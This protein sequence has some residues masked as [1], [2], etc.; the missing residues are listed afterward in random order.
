M[1]ENNERTIHSG[2]IIER[3]PMKRDALTSEE[4]TS[5]FID[6]FSHC[7]VAILASRNWIREKGALPPMADILELVDERAK[8]GK[9]LAEK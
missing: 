4:I 1:V 7:N 5:R 3:I 2:N 9:T 8:A 6:R